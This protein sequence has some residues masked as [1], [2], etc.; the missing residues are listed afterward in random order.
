[1]RNIK[2]RIISFS[3]KFFKGYEIYESDPD[4]EI[5]LPLISEPSIDLISGLNKVNYQQEILRRIQNT[6]FKNFTFNTQTFDKN[7]LE[8]YC[9]ITEDYWKY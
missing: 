9:K 1:M 5:K 7:T 8:N 3:R 4:A 2:N 6:I